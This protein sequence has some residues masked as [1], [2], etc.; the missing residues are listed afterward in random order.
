MKQ[1]L[2]VK[3]AKASPAR[4]ILVANSKGGCGKSTLATNLASFYGSTGIA[5]AI[6]DYDPQGSSSQ[7]LNYRNAEL[8]SI[9]GIKA[10]KSGDR[11][12][13][14][15][16][17][18]RVPRHIQRIIVDTPAALGGPELSEQI[19]L[20]DLIIVPVLPSP[21][22]T[23]AAARFIGQILLS[24][25]FRGSGKGLLVLANRVKQNTKSLQ[26]LDRFLCS[27]KLPQVGQIRDAQS[28]V[29]CAEMGMGIADMNDTRSNRD[30]QQ[31]QTV[32]DWIEQR[33][34][35]DSETPG[36]SPATAQNSDAVYTIV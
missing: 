7:W 28:Y 33:L 27:L 12:V 16:W 29:A 32:I 4:R 24:G 13:T 22:D 9:V 14:R 25:N 17:Y 18:M 20:A 30:R 35:G 11:S 10:Y 23:H 5:S 2:A 21:I 26:K 34:A 15:D 31:W 1:Q 3:Q 36:Q 19:R 8:P 6:L